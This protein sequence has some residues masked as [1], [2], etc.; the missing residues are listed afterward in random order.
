ME[1]HS[2]SIRIVCYWVALLQEL[3]L[4][5]RLGAH[6]TVRVYN[7]APSPKN[8]VLLQ[9][10]LWKVYST[11]NVYVECYQK[12]PIKLTFDLNN[13]TTNVFAFRMIKLLQKVFDAIVKPKGKFSQARAIS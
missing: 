5:Y 3:V 12:F 11:L 6:D 10:P 8:K 13:P 2:P 4:G 7:A 1:F 9:G